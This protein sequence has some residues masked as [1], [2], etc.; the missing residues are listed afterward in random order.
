MNNRSR[1]KAEARFAATDEYEP[2]WIEE[3][4]RIILASCH[5]K[6]RAF[7]TDP[8]RRVSALVGRRGGKTTGQRAR[9]L[10]RMIRNPGSKCLYIAETRPHAENLM[11]EPLKSTCDRLGLK[12]G[13]DVDF[14]ETKLRMTLLR[15]GSQLRLVGANDNS[16]V[17]KLR[18]DKFNEVG[19]DEA[20]SFP[21]RRLDNLVHRVIGPTL[22]DFRGVLSMFG[23]PGHILSGQFYDSTRQGSPHHYPFG[24]APEDWL[25]WSSHAWTLKDGADAGVPAMINAWAEALVEKEANKW[26]D[27]NPIWMREWLGRWAT[28]S[29]STVFRYKPYLDDGMPWNA[30]DPERV[31]PLKFAKLPSGFKDWLHVIGM[32]LGASDPFALTV[33]AF[34]PSDPER[35]IY[36][37]YEFL[38]REMYERSIAELLLGV[39]RNH[40]R[41]GG[42]IGEIGE[43][44]TAMVADLAGNGDTIL[45]ELGQVY[46][47]RIAGAEKGFKYK[48]PAIELANG[49]LLDG[50]IKV[51]KDSQLE[52]EMLQLQWEE[53]E[54]GRLHEDRRMANHLTD[55][56]I[57]ARNVIAKLFEGGAI[58]YDPPSTDD[59]DDDEITD[60][61][62]EDFS[63]MLA[64]PE[65]SDPWGADD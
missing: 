16:E 64:S 58:T 5:P 21:P 1:G 40:T 22:G 37:R 45:K 60:S 56:F 18:G 6:Q 36:Q 47:I 41:P 25:G 19:L 4:S 43:W 63:D 8:H 48:L 30:W 32:D 57:Y 35:N 49:D 24:T 11:W 38:Q 46:G 53:D 33:W 59:D 20:A 50:R 23:T 61:P 14:N 31:G 65:F 26:S 27:D 28:D 12:I 51:L 3:K 29:G 34:S 9:F 55:S 7:V 10:L 42:V 44:P 54:Y 15:N 13:R 17:N 39:T 62:A 2:E 52:Q